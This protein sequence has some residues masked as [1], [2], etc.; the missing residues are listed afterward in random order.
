[1]SSTLRRLS[2]SL[3]LWLSLVIFIPVVIV[4]GSGLLLQVK[5]EFD[6]IQPPTQKLQSAAPSMSFDDVLQA[7]QK[8]PQANI[9]TWD[10]IDRLDVRPSK[11]IIK[12]RGRNHWEVQINASTAEVLQVAYRRTDTIEAI[13]DGSWFFEG[14]KL[15]L[16]LPV[17]IV[18]F[19]LWLT[20]LVMLYTTLKSKYKKRYY[21]LNR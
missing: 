5:K 17:A 10:D 2:R 4:I 6:W 14:A 13:H 21:Q 11:G 18:L 12:I 9:Q 15:W 20:G 16:F 8:V 3:H 7:V 19:I 1:M